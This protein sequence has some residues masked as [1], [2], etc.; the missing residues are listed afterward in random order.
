MNH[1]KKNITLRIPSDLKDEI[2]AYAE[3]RGTTLTQLTLDYYRKIIALED[4]Q[5][6]EQI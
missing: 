1:N 6:A 2:L 3:R 5:E 4:R